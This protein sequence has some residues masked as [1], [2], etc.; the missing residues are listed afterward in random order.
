MKGGIDQRRWAKQVVD[1]LREGLKETCTDEE[2]KGYFSHIISNPGYRIEFMKKV[3]VP[4]RGKMTGIG[5]T[6]TRKAQIE[7]KTIDIHN[8]YMTGLVRQHLISEMA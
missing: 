8:Q 3:K 2:I 6:T 1:T 4:L 5:I 7:N